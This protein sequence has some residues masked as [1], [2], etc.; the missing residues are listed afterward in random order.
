LLHLPGDDI[1]SPK[2]PPPPPP[3]DPR[4]GYVKV[5]N[6]NRRFTPTLISKTKK[7]SLL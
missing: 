4:T 1:D 6:A 5:R 7:A 2:P 3:P